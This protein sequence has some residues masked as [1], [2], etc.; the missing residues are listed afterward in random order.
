MAR[1]IGF[2][3]LLVVIILGLFFGNINAETVILNYYWGSFQL[4]L[5]VAL[6]LGL[7]CGAVLGMLASLVVIIRLRHQV[8]KLRREARN[9]EQELANLRALPLKDNH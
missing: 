6:V 3:V 9:T 7:L 8:S 2:I 5:S 4:P 1:I